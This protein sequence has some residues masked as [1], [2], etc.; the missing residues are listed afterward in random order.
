MQRQTNMLNLFVEFGK[1]TNKQKQAAKLPTTCGWQFW[2]LSLLA[3]LHSSLAGVRV[4]QQTA[5]SQIS[6]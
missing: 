1:N 5:H 3:G 2:C 6:S 4:K